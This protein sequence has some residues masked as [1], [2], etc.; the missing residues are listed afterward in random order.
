MSSPEEVKTVR[1]WELKKAN[2]EYAVLK[3]AGSF[4][5]ISNQTILYLWKHIELNQGNLRY[6]HEILRAQD[7][8]LNLRDM[9]DTKEMQVFKINCVRYI[10]DIENRM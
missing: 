3:A 8:Y 2:D 7:G 9:K 4:T 5:P 6:L 1:N 10:E